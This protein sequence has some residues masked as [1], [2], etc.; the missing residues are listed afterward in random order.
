MPG[1]CGKARILRK[2][3]RRQLIVRDEQDIPAEREF[4]LTQSCQEVHPGV[5]AHIDRALYEPILSLTKS[6]EA[7]LPPHY[8]GTYTRVFDQLAEALSGFPFPFGYTFRFITRFHFRS[9]CTRRPQGAAIDVSIFLSGPGEK[10]WAPS[11]DYACL[12]SML[13]IY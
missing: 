5:C 13:G 3:T 9:S 4:T 7:A 12:C 6:L 1:L 8:E 11:A 10:S 2:H